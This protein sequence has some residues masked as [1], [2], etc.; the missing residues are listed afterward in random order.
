MRGCLGDEALWRIH[1]GEGSPA[2]RQHLARC[3]GCEARFQRLAC[4]LRVIR[5]VLAEPAPAR[6]A[7]GA[8]RGRGRLLPVAAAILI[9]SL[10]AAGGSLWG[11]W[12]PERG[13]P[14]PAREE[15]TLA[16]LG[17]VSAALFAAGDEN[18]VAAAPDPALADLQAA[19]EDDGET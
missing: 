9:V 8:A 14:A 18:Q 2:E 3:P 10:A 16:F 12:Q 4:D 13:H 17:E 7:P 6:L 15:E 19:L 11:R 5:S 1:E